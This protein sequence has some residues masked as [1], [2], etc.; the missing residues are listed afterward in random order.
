VLRAAGIVLIL[1]TPTLAGVALLLA[2][3]LWA[4]AVPKMRVRR[5]P[6]VASIPPLER[7]AANLRRLRRDVIRLENSPEPTPGRS[8]RLASLRSAYC[9]SLVIAC[10]ALEVPVDRADLSRRPD[11]EIYRVEAALRERGLDVAPTAIH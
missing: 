6:P 2:I 8:S 1:L 10:R 5:K 9:D 11:A 7:V 4:D 3:G